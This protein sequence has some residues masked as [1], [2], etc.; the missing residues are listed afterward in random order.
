MDS[1]SVLAAH[2]QATGSVRLKLYACR[3]GILRWYSERLWLF[4]RHT[5]RSGGGGYGMSQVWP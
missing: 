1:A 2:V 5:R 4:P 3:V